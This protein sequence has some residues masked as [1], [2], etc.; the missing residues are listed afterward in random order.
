MRLLILIGLIYI[1]YRALKS[2]A[3]QK[4]VATG[5]VRSQATGG[6]DDVMVKDPVC[7]VYFPQRNGI[8]L[9]HEGEDLYFCSAACKD[10]F[11]NRL[12]KAH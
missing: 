6:I 9:K 11:I 7:E 8:H 2:W 10:D 12:H 3:G 1:A 5:S 4:T